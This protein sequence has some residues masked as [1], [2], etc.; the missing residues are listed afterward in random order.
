MIND[1]HILRIM[2][3]NSFPAILFSY[4]VKTWLLCHHKVKIFSDP[5]RR[6]QTRLI[7]EPG[8]IGPT[9]H[10][11]LHRRGTIFWRGVKTK[12]AVCFTAMRPIVRAK[13]NRPNR[14]NKW[15]GS[16]S[17]SWR[18]P[19]LC[20]PGDLVYTIVPPL[21]IVLHFCLILAS[22]FRLLFLPF[23]PFFF[24]T[25]RPLQGRTFA[26]L[27]SGR[28]LARLTTILEQG[29]SN[30]TDNVNW[31]TKNWTCCKDNAG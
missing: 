16:M 12:T 11:H 14:S 30:A 5:R 24:L 3:K 25:V 28:S 27:E 23:R 18:N 2:S 8:R 10:L 6:T 7:G 22:T 17:C 20:H 1:P 9:P 21:L 31:W 19:H 29:R 4:F 15:D 13:V 26:F